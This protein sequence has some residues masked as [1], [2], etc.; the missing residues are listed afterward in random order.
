MLNFECI[1]LREVLE[2]MP[3][4]QTVRII[5]AI[6]SRE[7]LHLLAAEDLGVQLQEMAVGLGTEQ[8]AFFD[9]WKLLN[10]IKARQDAA[11]IASFYSVPFFIF[12]N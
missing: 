11:N 5:K 8:D 1:D 2:F 10:M 12:H 9:A 6:I 4:L 7:T 3:L